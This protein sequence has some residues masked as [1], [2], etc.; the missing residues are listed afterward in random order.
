[1][2]RQEQGQ[3]KTIRYFRKMWPT[4]DALKKSFCPNNCYKVLGKEIEATTRWP[5]VTLSQIDKAYGQE[6]LA[7]YFATLMMATIYEQGNAGQS[8]KIPMRDFNASLFLAQYG[9][10]CTMYDLMIYTATYRAQY[11]PDYV[12]NGDLS[13]IIK[14]FPKYLEHKGKVIDENKLQPKAEEEDKGRGKKLVGKAALEYYLKTAAA[15]GDNLL[16]G[17]LVKLGIVSVEHAK[18]VMATYAP[19]AF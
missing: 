6:G 8:C 4:A 9:H 17:G 16:E 19:T 5:Q 7:L 3:S 14:R 10:R 2:T 12:A 1:M 18:E 11:K 13:D 15:R